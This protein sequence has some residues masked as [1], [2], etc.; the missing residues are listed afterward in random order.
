MTSKHSYESAKTRIRILS[1]KSTTVSSSGGSG[2][3]NNH[4]GEAAAARA[5]AADED[6]VA[7]EIREKA[8]ASSVTSVQL[9]FDHAAVE[10]VRWRVDR[11]GQLLETIK[12]C[13]ESEDG[14]GNSGVK[15]G[16]EGGQTV[17][18]STFLLNLAALKVRLLDEQS[19]DGGV[20]SGDV[21]RAGTLGEK[22]GAKWVSFRADFSEL[23]FFH[24]SNLGGAA[25]NSYMWIRHEQCS[26]NG[27][28]QNIDPLVCEVSNASAS[29]GV[30]LLLLTCSNEVLGRG[31]AG[32]ENAL[33]S[34]GTVGLTISVI[35]YPSGGY[36]T[37]S[38][39][40]CSLRGGTMMAPGGRLD[41]VKAVKELLMGSPKGSDAFEEERPNAPGGA[42]G[43]SERLRKA[44][45]RARAQSAEAPGSREAAQGRQAVGYA[46]SFEDTESGTSES[47]PLT[48]GI[49]F[50]IDLHDLALCYEPTAEP[51]PP[52]NLSKAP[53]NFRNHETRA[54]LSRQNSSSS[55]ASLAGSPVS[56]VLAAAALR[57]SSIL[58]RQAG[59]PG[60][61]EEEGEEEAQE[62]VFDIWLRDAA[63]L[64]LDTAMRRPAEEGFTTSSLAQAGF[65]QVKLFC[66]KVVRRHFLFCVFSS[67]ARF[68]FFPANVNLLLFEV[69]NRNCHLRFPQNGSVHCNFPE[70]SPCSRLCK[71]FF[72]ALFL[73]LSF[74]YESSSFSFPFQLLAR[75]LTRGEGFI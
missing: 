29:R 74:V 57:V 22:E 41:W 69:G 13:Q 48:N 12:G 34:P 7:L 66:M 75:I 18:Q 61:L 2:V 1:A 33:A 28:L 25:E 4:H 26:L 44:P 16:L 46:W 14:E 3:D 54:S 36:E 71:L 49:C 56:A 30:E 47:S 64:I 52:Q 35:A 15:E 6:L 39:V 68:S 21:E 11:L 19:W 17:N 27:F 42:K 60:K 31:D 5:S 23:T 62:Q 32:D 10:V 63:L 43:A 20:V 55:Q 37:D 9:S 53:G 24:V 72:I 67:P 65:V 45:E 58:G 59:G 38:I 40:A 8:I 73:I 51:A 50:L 70:E